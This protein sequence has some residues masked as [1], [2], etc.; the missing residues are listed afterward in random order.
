MSTRRG[1]CALVV[2]GALPRL[3]PAQAAAPL[4][5]VQQRLAVEPVVRGT[6]EQRKTVRGFR[7][8]LLSAGDFVVSRQRGVIWRT[9]EPFASTLV[10]TRERVQAR[11]ADGSVARTLDAAEEP[12]LRAISETLFG[13][14]AADFGVLAQRFRIEGELVGREGWKL[15]LLPL[16]PALAR[17]IE[18]IA[19]DGDRFLRNV[20]L[21]EAS[22]DQARIRLGGH[23]TDTA[24][25]PDE[26][27]QLG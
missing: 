22:G 10:V 16:D 14:L 25:R 26:E 18:R 1:F 20:R 11:Q 8:P 27:A 23:A 3:A 19:F 13:V 5:E 24:L 6:F 17:W 7:N 4:R 12:A 21:H 2:A 9:R 15:L